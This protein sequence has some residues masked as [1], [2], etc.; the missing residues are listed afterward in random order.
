[1]ENSL[2]NIATGADIN[3]APS[4]LRLRERL[5]VTW[6]R[7]LR[8]GRL[9]VSFPSGAL[10]TF[11]GAEDG[12]QAHLQ[13]NS[14]RLVAR[15]LAA[16]DVG[17]A[18]SYMEGEWDTPDLA[19]L[20]ALGC[21]NADALSGALSPSWTSRLIG[22]LRH[23][24]R[25]N[26]RQGSRR[27]IAAHYDLG[28]DFYA[29]WL[30]KT[31]SYSSA[32]FESS[33]EDMVTGQRRKYL[34][35]ARKLDLKPGERV[36]EIG[37]GWGG[38]AEIAAQEFG[39]RIVG[40]TLST[41]QAA[42]ARARMQSAGLTD[43]VEIRLQ[44]YRDID[45]TF[46]KIVSV[47]M[48]EAVG[49]RYWPS[50]FAALDR[51]LKP[52]GRAALQIITIDESRFS[53]Y[54]DAPDFIQRY[55]FPGGMLPSFSAFAKSASEGGFTVADTAFFGPSYAETLRRWDRDFRANWPAIQQLGFDQRF[56]R[57]WHYYLRYC[58]I[59]FDHGEID[60]GQFLLERA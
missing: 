10:H 46:D 45:E 4:F 56:H 1:M 17:F 42:F 24:L 59:G 57:M 7:R 5:F 22:R 34:R 16:G 18:E 53:N 48:F 2:S 28:N 43:Q 15:V 3:A 27:N 39:C 47:E 23:A 54:R 32:L 35:L 31:M 29:Q 6:L 21:R 41:E 9:T 36:L 19:T 44:D 33:E 37:C 8:F 14:L 49:E 12:P 40:L 13:V 20:L 11:E 60:V 51:C 25:A 55:I 30:D 38:F 26:S 50:Y 58:E 52:G